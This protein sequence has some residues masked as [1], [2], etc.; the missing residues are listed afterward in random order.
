MWWR[1]LRSAGLALLVGACAP[2]ENTAAGA[3]QAPRASAQTAVPPDP[4]REA[5][6]KLVVA[7]ILDQLPS[8]A[9][10]R[11]LSHL[12]PRGAIRQAIGRGAYFARSHYDSATTYTAV[13][14]AGVHTGAAASSH[15]VQ[16][17]EVWDAA[18]RQAVS[19]VDDGK[20]AVIG[21]ETEFASPRVLRVPT[22]ADTLERETAGRALTV[23]LSYKDR[24]S[25]LSA[26]QTP[27]L[28][29]W[30]DTK[31]GAFTTSSYYAK[32]LP[33][34][35]RQW[36]AAYPVSAAMKEWQ[37]SNPQDLQKLLGPDDAPGEGDWQQ[38]GTSFP[39][40]ARRS[41]EPL[42]A[43]RATPDS[44]D[45]LLD[46]ARQSV[47]AL[48]LG[49]DAVPD[50]L[51]LS[52]SATD[53]VGHIFGAESWEY[54]DNLRRTDAAL[55]RFLQELEAQT[56]IAVL[57]TT[58]HGVAPLLERASAV[59]GATRIWPAD[60]V[61]RMNDA[62]SKRFRFAEPVVSAFVQPFVYF[63]P[64]VR[65]APERQAIVTA[66]LAA[67]H[68]I[69][70][71]HSAYDVLAVRPAKNASEALTR[72]VR[73]SIAKEAPGDLFVVT[74]EH[75]VVD[76][77]M[78]RGAGTNHGSPWAYDQ[79]VPV[80]FWGPAVTPLM[81]AT[82]VDQLRVAATLSAL[83]GVPAPAAALSEKLPGSP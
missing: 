81:D 59:A 32:E 61:D 79:Y 20:H 26:G 41:P 22:V 43:F 69:P 52:I 40:D 30:Y 72:Q 34:W 49:K 57:I 4:S 64:A 24:A 12:S 60:L 75:S 74:A 67:L 25:V 45:Y 38:L 42:S 33:A 37:P 36:Q 62:L 73:S 80:V 16:A 35:L 13:G 6:A 2:R 53:Y 10:D 78:P 39:H 5:R 83:L 18:R 71:V 44:T 66:A 19:V 76:A 63:S 7:V 54:V 77:A 46:L 29:L 65:A 15:G 50:L 82:P 51:L 9:L 47:R 23:S 8:W 70:G 31:Q 56:S 11:Y 17:N 21:K 55:G 14:H 3:P 58:D 68:A 1:Q 28:V 27:D 48:E